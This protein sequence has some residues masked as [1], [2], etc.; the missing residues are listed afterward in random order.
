M[1]PNVDLQ[2][3]LVREGEQTE[4]KENV[5][6]I[7]DVLKTLSAFANDLANLG[8]G[9]VICGAREEKDQNGFPVVVKTGLTA[10]QL[11]KLEN[12]VLAKCRERISPPITPLVEELPSD[13]EDRRILVF[14]QPAT[15]HAHMLRSNDDGA[16]HLC[17]SADLR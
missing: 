13:V 3:L 9:Y 5:A 16:R 2:A 15:N 6:D 8:G 11:K 17:A 10:S 12:E 4:W 1:T 14:V 7:Y